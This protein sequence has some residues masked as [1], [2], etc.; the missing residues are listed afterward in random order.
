MPENSEAGPISRR[1][2]LKLSAAGLAALVLR[3]SIPETGEILKKNEI[4]LAALRVENRPSESDLEKAVRILEQAERA[5]RTEP[6]DLLI[7]PEYSFNLHYGQDRNFEPMPL[8]I[9][10]DG[11]EFT[12][13]RLKSHNA[14]RIILE[15][16]QSLAKDYRTNLI[17]ATFYDPTDKI[18]HTTA[19]FI[20][21]M[22]EIGGLK[23]KNSLPPVGKFEIKRGGQTFKILPMIC[24]EVWDKR[25]K[26]PV[27]S[28][29][30]SIPPDWVKE[31]APWDIFAHCMAQGDLDF[32][33]LA[34]IVQGEPIPKDSR[35]TGNEQW[36]KNVF[37]SYYGE[38]LPYLNPDS[39]ILITDV[40]MAGCFNP[41]LTALNNYQDQGEYITAKF[42]VVDQGVKK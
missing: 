15:M 8:I 24:G 18:A 7:T 37:N 5:L 1:D 17:L 28:D 11:A 40:N 25:I 20:N 39:P 38:Y 29:F 33:K 41:S 2:F 23:R 9:R 19:V 13:D 12:V 10:Q 36:Q 3:G 27:T 34:A 4:A 21:S 26:D 14:A 35:F 22:G 31:N 32:D 30:K 16:G 6:L 42:K